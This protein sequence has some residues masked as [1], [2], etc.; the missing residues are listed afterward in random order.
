MSLET[1][2][3]LEREQLKEE[4]ERL[5]KNILQGDNF[6][7]T[8]LEDNVYKNTGKQANST[9]VESVP[10]E[11]I[12]NIDPSFK[13]I[14]QNSSVEAENPFGQTID[15]LKFKGGQ[16]LNANNFNLKAKNEKASKV[17]KSDIPRK[18][19]DD[20]EQWVS[21]TF[22]SYFPGFSNE[23]QKRQ[24]YLQQQQ[25]E[26]HEKL[27]KYQKLNA[28]SRT[29]TK[30]KLRSKNAATSGLDLNVY[31]D[32]SISSTYSPNGIALQRSEKTEQEISN[33]NLVAK[34]SSR[35]KLLQDLRHTDL[36]NIIS[37]GKSDATKRNHY[38]DIE[39][40]SARKKEYQ[41]ELLHQIEEKRRNIQLLKEKERQ[42]EEA[43]T[44][45]L[46]EQINT[47]K[48]EEQLEKEKIHAE[49]VYF[50][51]EQNR[52]KRQY[53][54]KN[55]EKDS[56]LLQ[57]PKD[58]ANSNDEA[59]KENLVSS[60]K[61]K[62]YQYFSNSAHHHYRYGKLSPTE[63]IN[64]KFEI[65][66]PE[67]NKIE[68]ECFHL[69]EK[70]CPVCDGP[71]KA[72]ENFCLRCQKNLSLH[73]NTMSTKNFNEKENS[74]NQVPHHLKKDTD[75]EYARL[76]YSLI[77]ERCDRFYAFCPGCLNKSD[78]CRACRSQRNICMNCRRTLCSF[79]LEEVACGKD[80]EQTHIN[81]SE[82]E[83]E[84]IENLVN[85]SET[86]VLF[87]QQNEKDNENESHILAS[88]NNKRNNLNAAENRP[89]FSTNIKKNSIF[90]NN[91]DTALPLNKKSNVN[92]QKTSDIN[93]NIEVLRRDVDKRLMR[94]VNNYGDLALQS[95]GTQTTPDAT[96]RRDVVLRNEHNLSIP[97]LRE[98][99]K[100][101]RN[102]ASDLFQ[103]NNSTQLEN[104][105]KR[106]E[107]PA[108]QKHSISTTSPNVLTQVGA[109]RKQLQAD[110][111]FSNNCH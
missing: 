80:I 79:C 8:N 6:Q 69:G 84:K 70:I 32:R 90:H 56:S 66:E 10:N 55:M 51:A 35:Y 31:N 88:T 20:M 62:V 17:A 21:D 99:P 75:P 110:L 16:P 105:N 72:Y 45:R 49:K 29:G 98:M 94:Y 47:M 97:L 14:Y 33:G 43:L 96:G 102:E 101:T 59:N 3:A 71:L 107:I 100:M 85:P 65:N 1:I 25:H 95:R 77:C 57:K 28:E 93:L 44:R 82:E 60:N 27:K 41:L 103:K 48:L 89:P 109:I 83:P 13:F 18:Y 68:Q 7:T 39:S 76:S 9:N 11:V 108:V 24:N 86:T 34:N 36:A 4:Y 58:L 92:N 54:L 53:I 78:V 15:D 74:N 104:L 2:L 12:S 52:L 63:L 67:T 91:Y 23:Y 46:Q 106:W 37:D 38:Q 42:Q 30:L 111:L 87:L 50:E 5:K 73:L 61:N 19:Q 40:V 26:N 22:F 81:E 64:A